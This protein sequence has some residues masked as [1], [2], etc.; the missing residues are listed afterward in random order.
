MEKKINIAEI[1]KDCPKGMELDCVMFDKVTLVEV[2]FDNCDYPISISVSGERHSLSKYGEWFYEDIA[3]CVIFP[4]GKTTWEGFVPPCKFNDGDVLTN[5]RG[6]I[7]IYKGLMYY[8]KNLI[9]FYCGY[10][11]RDCRFV[12]K[13]SN[14]LHFGDINKFHLAT[15][16]E[17]A[18]LF[19]AIKENGY[20]WDAEKKCLEK[21]PKFKVG[22]S[23]K[24]WI[25]RDRDEN[26]W[27][28]KHKP[29]YNS[30]T[31][32]FEGKIYL[33]QIEDSIFPEITFENSPQEVEFKLKNK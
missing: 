18:K 15:E 32:Q 1:L 12:P 31:E 16:E 26:L 27:F 5:D 7:C 25:A 10:R 30:N 11:I 22:D 6:S 14:D 20:K 9:D 17:K 23:M 24:L 21:L 33:W 8:N 2:D 29:I 3:K 28:Y 4:K 19:N 13:Y